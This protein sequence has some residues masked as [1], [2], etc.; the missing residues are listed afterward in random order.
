M[1]V[2]FY[3]NLYFFFMQNIEKITIKAKNNKYA[4]IKIKD[5]SHLKTKTKKVMH[6]KLEITKST[7][8]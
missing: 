2:L 6:E 3:N 1:Y 5:C 8:H 7:I 4:L